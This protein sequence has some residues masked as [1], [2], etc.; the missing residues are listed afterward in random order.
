MSSVP[1]CGVGWTPL[2][3]NKGPKP[4]HI[5]S[6]VKT[7]NDIG[8]LWGN[9]IYIEIDCSTLVYMVVSLGCLYMGMSQNQMISLHGKCFF[10]PVAIRQHNVYIPM[11]S[12]LICGYPQHW[13]LWY[14]VRVP[15]QGCACIL[16]CAPRKS[17]LQRLRSSVRLGPR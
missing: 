3:F 11:Q 15:S 7:W 12:F 1:T 10:K 2:N 13:S 5:N 4:L 6:I 14:P 8:V 16:C 9:H 17:S